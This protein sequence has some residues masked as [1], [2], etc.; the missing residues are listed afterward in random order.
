MNLKK[1]INTAFAGM[2]LTAAGCGFFPKTVCDYGEVAQKCNRTYYNSAV[3]LKRDT[4]GGTEVCSF[5]AYYADAK[6]ALSS[7]DVNCDGTADTFSKYKEL[8]S[9][10]M[11]LLWTVS[12]EGN[13]EYFESNYDKGFADG[14]FDDMKAGGSKE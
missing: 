4:S 5:T 11:K 2:A 12:R 14:A 13:E 6:V 7:T 9:G 10:K 3:Q 8:E 1:I